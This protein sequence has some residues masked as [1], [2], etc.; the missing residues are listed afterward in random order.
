MPRILW[1]G[2]FFFLVSCQSTAPRD[3]IANTGAPFYSEKHLELARWGLGADCCRASGKN[4]AVAAG[5]P[6]SAAAGERIAAAGG[7]V[8]DVA[9]ATAFAL[10]VETPHWCG[11]GG[12]G[13]LTLILRSGIAGKESLKS[14]FVDFRET[15]PRRATRDMYL[16][17]GGNVVPGLST[18]GALSV[19]TPGFVRGMHDVHKKWGRLSWKKVL[20]P[21]IELAEKGFPI[22]ISLADSIAKNR[23]RLEK[24]PYAKSLVFKKDGTAYGVGDKLVQKD[25]GKTLRLVAAKGP[26]GFYSG[27]IAKAIAKLM[28]EQ[29]GILDGEDLA[30][31]QS[32]EREPVKFAWKEFQLVGA[33]PP[34]AGGVLIAQMLGVLANVD[35][36]TTAG[37]W[38]KYTHLLSQVMKRAYADRSKFI[39]DPDFVRREFLSLIAPEY[40]TLV[41]QRLV[42]DRNQPSAEIAPGEPDKRETHSTTHLSVLDAEGNGVSSTVTING[43]FGSA[44]AVPGWGFFLN[45]E[46]DDF[47]AKPGVANLYGLTSDETN[48]VGP[49]KRPVSSMSPTLVMK[50]GKTVLAVGGGGGSRIIS[51]TFQVLLNALVVFPGDLR[52]AVFAPRMHH[53]WMPDTLDLEIGSP[54]TGIAKLE[55]MGHDVRVPPPWFAWEYAVARDDSGTLWA[56]YDARNEGGVAAR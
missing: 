40:L 44:L 27:G 50:D 49:G 1:V 18:D 15:A 35:L 45:N 2:L 26:D 6:N 4:V 46:M 39:G 53:Q 9:V 32:K 54:P 47:S 56:V 51:S 42:L 7:N 55:A 38:T 28:R 14:S 13:F 52:R 29:K 24:Q 36:Q 48:A 12:G 21:A 11:L 17:A 20:E 5:G 23:G 41:R 16:D 43:G 30:T 34:S 3:T 37:D 19:A 10:S 31:Y 8:V 22:G 33:P 25:L